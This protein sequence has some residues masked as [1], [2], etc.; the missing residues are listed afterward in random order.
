RGLSASVRVDGDDRRL[1]R[2]ILAGVPVL[3]ETWHEARP[4]DGMGHYRLM[5]GY[6]DASGQWIAYDTFDTR[7]LVKGQPYD[8]IRLPYDEP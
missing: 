5:V 7:D 1:R 6:D 8:G 3:I 2:L 4:N